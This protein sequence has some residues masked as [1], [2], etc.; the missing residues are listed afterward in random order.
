MKLL[1]SL[2]VSSIFSLP[3]VAGEHQVYDYV[4]PGDL[5]NA[6]NSNLENLDND[7]STMEIEYSI[8][9]DNLEA[10][11]LKQESFIVEP[12]NR[13]LEMIYGIPKR[14]LSG[15]LNT[16]R[17]LLWSFN[18]EVDKLDFVKSLQFASKNKL[19][20][21][22]V[23]KHRR[24]NLKS[25]VVGRSVF[26]KSQ[27]E[28]V[29][30]NASILSLSQNNHLRV[31]DKDSG[32]YLGLVCESCLMSRINEIKALNEKRMELIDGDLVELD[33]FQGN[34]RNYQGYN[35]VQLVYPPRE[36]IL[37]NPKFL[38]TQID[39]VR[40]KDN[41][42]KKEYSSFDAVQLSLKLDVDLEGV[43]NRTIKVYSWNNDLQS[44]AFQTSYIEKSIPVS[45]RLSDESQKDYL[46]MLNYHL[47]VDRIDKVILDAI[48]KNRMIELEVFPKYETHT[49]EK[50]LEINVNKSHDLM[51]FI[52]I[53]DEVIGT[54]KE[55]KSELRSILDFIKN[56]SELGKGEE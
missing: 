10:L 18:G 44:N 42:K 11:L 22:N 33:F 55:T 37:I 27:I 43:S 29:A 45:F 38:K 6:Y 24:V 54:K 46:N 20:L 50:F 2:I 41:H 1:L 31:Q 7:F 13:T 52:R 48:F 8:L 12:R 4:E 47:L 35:A 23:K 53:S 51:G 36:T 34:N 17:K 32:A 40:I 16:T 39:I 26:K 3:L 28:F 19:S 30:V 25:F 56:E 5:L 21:V 14:P 15:S 9:S 49:R